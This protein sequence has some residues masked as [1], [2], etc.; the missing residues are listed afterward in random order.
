MAT[1][2]NCLI[3]RADIN[4][5][6]GVAP[7]VRIQALLAASP[8]KK[9]ITLRLPRLLSAAIATES[10]S[11]PCYPLADSCPASLANGR[12]KRAISRNR[13]GHK[14]PAPQRLET[15]RRGVVAFASL[16]MVWLHS[17]IRR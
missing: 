16:G 15:A 13:A 7:R 9:Q 5:A 3:N 17:L 1:L 10:A 14:R 8:F 4:S 6:R 11:R 2:H 12:P